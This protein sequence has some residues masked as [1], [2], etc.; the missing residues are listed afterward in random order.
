ME[1]NLLAIGYDNYTNYIKLPQSVL[2]EF[3]QP[4]ILDDTINNVINNVINDGLNNNLKKKKKDSKKK[5]PHLNLKNATAKNLT[6]KIKPPYYFYIESGIGTSAYC[7]VQDFTTD[8]GMVIIPNHILDQMLI[9]GSDFVTVRYVSDVPKGKF[10]V[11][12]PVDKEIFNIN[13]LDKFLEIILSGYCILYQNQIIN[14]EYEN[15][16]YKILIKEIMSVDDSKVNII[17]IVNIDLSIDI[18]NKFLEEELI[19]KKELEMK[20]KEKE[21]KAKE[22][23]MKAKELETKSYTIPSTNSKQ[24]FTGEGNI[25]G[26]ANIQGPILDPVL[27]REIRLQKFIEINNQNKEATVLKQFNKSIMEFGLCES[28][29]ESKQSEIKINKTK[30]FEL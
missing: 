12:E 28:Q 1:W 5:K 26:G 19:Q 18:H 10:V 24:F 22:K 8:E 13:D 25:L 7:G 3:N 21:M 27:L 9:N 20:A 6:E 17:D 29:T 14:F 15:N 11:I 4:T 23:E 2:V 30:E 16:I